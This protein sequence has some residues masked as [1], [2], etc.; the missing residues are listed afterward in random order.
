MEIAAQFTSVSA[1]YRYK[2][3]ID[4]IRQSHVDENPGNELFGLDLI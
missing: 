2:R 3:S 4:Y 1:G